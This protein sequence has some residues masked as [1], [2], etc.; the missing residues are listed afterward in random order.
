MKRPDG[1]G[2][3][4]TN[5]TGEPAG[6]D[7][8]RLRVGQKP[9]RRGQRD[10]RCAAGERA[11][12]GEGQCCGDPDQPRAETYGGQH[13]GERIDREW[14]RRLDTLGKKVSVRCGDKIEDGVAQEVDGDGNLILRRSDGSVVII[15][16]GDVTLRAH[17][18]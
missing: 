16:A 1:S 15:A 5:W 8:G 4:G 18:Y 10:E 9:G 6:T 3:R 13:R 11:E 2:F 14:H 12:S 7:A 17:N